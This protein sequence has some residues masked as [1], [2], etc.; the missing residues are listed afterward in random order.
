MLLAAVCVAGAAHAESF[1]EDTVKAAYLYRFASYVNW[2]GDV[3]HGA[4]FTITVLGSPAVAAELRRLVHGHL[5][6]DHPVEVRE[7]NGA[8]DLGHPQILY[9]GEGHTEELRDLAPELA[10][11][12]TLLVTDDE[13][14]LNWGSVLNFVT[15][16]RRIRFEVSLTAADRAHLKISSDLLTVA[17]RVRGGRRQSRDGCLP[18][19]L[20]DDESACTI[21]VADA[22]I[23]LQRGRS[24]HRAP[25]ELV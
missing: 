17:V 16:D 5:I 3:T 11:G 13:E 1:S 20:P 8:R 6:E 21:R 2:P 19:I 15:L 24:R 18:E 23:G 10:S 7:V 4:P 25:R 14:G 9:V 22:A 12:S